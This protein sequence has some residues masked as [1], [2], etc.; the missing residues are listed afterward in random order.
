MK[1]KKNSEKIRKFEV[2]DECQQWTIPTVA[3]GICVSIFKDCTIFFFL[4][5]FRVLNKDPYNSQCLPLH[6]SVLVELKKSNSKSPNT[7]KYFE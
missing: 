6:I 3:L 1:K 5:F 7:R 2:E 4:Y